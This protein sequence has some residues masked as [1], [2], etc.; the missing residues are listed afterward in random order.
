[1]KLPIL[2]TIGIN[3]LNNEILLAIVTEYIS[4][5]VQNIF[6][7]DEKKNLKQAKINSRRGSQMIGKK[8]QT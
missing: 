3:T 2:H 1:M 5:F 6:L 4:P 7:C 8:R